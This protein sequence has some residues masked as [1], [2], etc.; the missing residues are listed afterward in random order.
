MGDF[1]YP[2]IDWITFTTPE[3]QYHKA[4]L[5]LEVT[6]DCHLHQHKTDSIHHRGNQLLN[7]L[8]LIFTNE[9]SMVE[10]INFTSLLGKSS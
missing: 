9:E 1:N 6:C 8:D 2:E 4:S 7:S 5:F 3:E 10:N